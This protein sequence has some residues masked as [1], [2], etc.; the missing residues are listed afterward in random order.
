MN[1]RFS[2]AH[3]KN[4]VIISADADFLRL[5]KNTASHPGLIYWASSKHFGQIVND[6]DAMCFTMTA[7]DFQGKV[8]FL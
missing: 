6:L 4:C 1:L 5:L 3:Q 2:F 8:F 7:N